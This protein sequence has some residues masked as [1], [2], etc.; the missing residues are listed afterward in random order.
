MRSASKTKGTAISCCVLSHSQHAKPY[1][2]G[3]GVTQHAS[4]TVSGY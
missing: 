1:T 3:F 2:F 4:E